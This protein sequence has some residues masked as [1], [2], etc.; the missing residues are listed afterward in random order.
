MTA[1]ELLVTIAGRLG[2]KAPQVPFLDS[3]QIVLDIMS[4][5]LWEHKSDLIKEEIEEN[6]GA[7]VGEFDVETG[8]LGFVNN[9]WIYDPDTTLVPADMEYARTLTDAGTPQYYRLRGT[10]GTPYPPNE[11]AIVVKYEAYKKPTAITAL[12]DE[13]PFISLFDQLIAD[14]VGKFCVAGMGLTVDPKFEAFIRMNMDNIVGYRPT[15]SI[16]MYVVV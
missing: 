2:G 5:H 10:T 16:F 15:K 3:V 11:D 14:A 12:T 9:P 6:I 4:N 1:G 13:L 7:A 8:F